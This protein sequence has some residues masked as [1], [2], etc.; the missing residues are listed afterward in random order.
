MVKHFNYIYAKKSSILVLYAR[1]NNGS[2][3]LTK[4]PTNASPKTKNQT[5]K[6][7][8]SCKYQANLSNFESFMYVGPMNHKSTR[9]QQGSCCNI[10]RLC[11]VDYKLVMGLQMSS[12][13]Y[14]VCFGSHKCQ[15]NFNI[16][17]M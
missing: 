1:H 13:L 12:I 4:A 6:S 7:F 11:E 16:T 3:N 8:F 15:I 10:T 5:L 9:T 17:P 14:M 2:P